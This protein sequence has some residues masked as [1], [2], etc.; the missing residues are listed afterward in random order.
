MFSL[1]FL[2]TPV[3][4]DYVKVDWT[5]QTW[6]SIRDQELATERCFGAFHVGDFIYRV[7]HSVWNVNT[8]KVETP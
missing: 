2:F 7:S 8:A 6:F 1:I 4:K 5:T 3:L